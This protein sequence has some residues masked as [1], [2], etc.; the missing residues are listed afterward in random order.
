MYGDCV[1]RRET[2]HLLSSQHP[3]RT[4]LEV[5]LKQGHGI[6]ETIKAWHLK[7]AFAID[8]KGT[9]KDL[10]DQGGRIETGPLQE[11]RLPGSLL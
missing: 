7:P 4:Q 9:N 11:R 10:P 2:W 1:S 6:L 5:A 3:E 8:L